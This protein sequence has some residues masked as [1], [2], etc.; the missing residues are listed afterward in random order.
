MVVTIPGVSC[1]FIMNPGLSPLSLPFGL[2]RTIGLALPPIFQIRRL[3]PRD[4]W[5]IGPKSHS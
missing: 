3:R 4:I 1:A 2:Y 5:V